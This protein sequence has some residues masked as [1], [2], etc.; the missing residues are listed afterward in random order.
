MFGLRSRRAARS[1][2]IETAFERD[3]QAALKKSGRGAAYILSCG[4]L[5]GLGGFLFWADAT[6]I[7]EVTR[8]SGKVIPGQRVQ[9]VQ[10]LEGGILTEV[11]VS[12]GD[13]VAARAPVVTLDAT[14]A[15]SSLGEVRRRYESLRASI[16]RLRAEARG[17]ELTFPVDLKDTA[18]QVVADARNL[19]DA[20]TA[21][22]RSR[23]D[24]ARTR[25]D[26][27]RQEIA[28]LQ[29]KR[30]DLARR[31][32][33]A[34][35]ERDVSRPLADRGIVPRIAMMR[36]EREVDRLAGELR[37]LDMS[38]PRARTAFQ[39]AQAD[40]NEIELDVRQ[41]AAAGLADA[42][43][44][45][46]DVEA[47]LSTRADRLSR[48]SVTS[49]VQ[50]R[51][52]NVL[53]STVGSVVRPGEDIAEI[54]PTGGQLLIEARVKPNDVADLAI[55]QPA[56]VRITAYD[57]TVYG[58]LEATVEHVS[59]DT[60]RDERGNT[61]YRARLRAA[62][63]GLVYQGRELPVIPGMTA[64]VEVLG[65]SK[66]VLDYLLNPLTKSKRQLDLP[67]FD[68]TMSWFGF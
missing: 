38:I 37:V 8:A 12:A 1:K 34:R 26:Q 48:T 11:H 30:D 7:Q 39:Q 27:R 10:N 61:Y 55:G 5:A 19:F 9:V 24:S 47:R 4:V 2:N 31:L 43:T 41:R 56:R 13:T 53:K 33:L 3:A 49:P 17:E 21:D 25:A 64:Q 57:S 54:V 66:T 46:A 15:E 18:P 36:L 42:L 68:T 14:I 67:S 32:R 29:G 58:A 40:V 23:L 52:K 44:E 28:E 35:Q 20:N 45:M 16:A 63:S 22:L 59:A 62:G 65:G 50:G 60:I 6:T 51:V